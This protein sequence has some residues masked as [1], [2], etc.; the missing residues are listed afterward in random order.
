MVARVDGWPSLPDGRLVVLQH[1]AG[2]LTGLV[3]AVAPE[4]SWRCL[5]LGAPLMQGGHRQRELYL[6][7]RCLTPVSAMNADQVQEL[8]RQQAEAE[9]DAL[10]ADLGRALAGRVEIDEAQLVR[11][12]QQALVMHSL[13][14]VASAT[15]LREAGFRKPVPGDELLRLEVEVGESG[16]RLDAA[17]SRAGAWV[18]DCATVSPDVALCSWIQLPSEAPRGQVMAAVLRAWRGAFPCGPTPARLAPGSLY[19]RHR[20]LLEPA[21][22]LR[23][24]G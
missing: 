6:P 11:A 9:A 2:L 7:E 12:G 17:Q 22:R 15:A 8:V 19:E 21:L 3:G 24:H 4:P 18:L 1:G 10:V 13:E 23:A 20:A 14:V 16:L 5:L